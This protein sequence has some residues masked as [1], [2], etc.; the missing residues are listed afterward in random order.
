MRIRYPFMNSQVKCMTFVYYMFVYMDGEK[1]KGNS[2]MSKIAI[3]QLNQV[4]ELFRIKQ[5]TPACDFLL[6]AMLYYV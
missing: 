3:W 1:K 5:Q 2:V 6:L 4:C